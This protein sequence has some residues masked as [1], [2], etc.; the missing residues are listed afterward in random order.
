MSS[1]RAV[2]HLSYITPEPNNDNIAAPMDLPS[3]TQLKIMKQ[4]ITVLLSAGMLFCAQSAESAN[5][6]FD[7]AKRYQNPWGSTNPQNSASGFAPWTFEVYNPPASSPAFFIDKTRNA[8]AINVPPGYDAAW[9]SFTGD[10][11]LDAGQTFSTHILFTPPGHSTTGT[12]TEAIDFFAQ[13]P[14]VPSKYLNFG[15]QVLGLYLGQTA[16]GGYAFGVGIHNTLSDENP[17]KWVTLPLKLTGTAKN[18]Q[19]VKVVYT[20]LAG[21]HWNLSIQSQ[22]LSVVLASAQFGPTWNATTGVDA[23]RYFAS[24]AGSSPI[25]PLEWNN[26]SVK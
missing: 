2:R 22:G 24:Q 14:T 10:G 21:G 26:M 4:L 8:W 19:S 20:Q 11:Q 7:S 25:R 5:P 16:S 12:P 23:V 18:P 15:H 13:S 9:V 1:R 3:I 6:A 17:D